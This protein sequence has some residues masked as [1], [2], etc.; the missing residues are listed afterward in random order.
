MDDA[1]IL[2][3]L[4]GEPVSAVAF[5]TDYVELHFNGPIF[6]F[7]ANPTVIC[8]S[9]RFT[10]PESGSRDA[11]CSLI[12]ERPV[13][14]DI[15]DDVSITLNMDG[16]CKLTLPLDKAHARGGES[17]HFVGGVNEPVQVW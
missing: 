3:P 14:I 2:A 11:L 15:V 4:I 12:G 13:S 6:R 1:T 17:A 8:G 7:I 9:T 5:V 16:G 10:F